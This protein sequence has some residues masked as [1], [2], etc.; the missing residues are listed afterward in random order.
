MQPLR[1]TATILASALLC[2]AAAQ[3]QD[4]PKRLA[5]PGADELKD[6]AKQTRETFKSSLS[7][8]LEQSDKN[9]V[10]RDMLA[11][12]EGEKNPALRHAM[13]ELSI[14]LACDSADLNLAIQ[15]VS[16]IEEAY[17]ED[18]APRLIQAAGD[19]AKAVRTPES[20]S[21]YFQNAQA[22][23]SRLLDRDQ[24]ATARKVAE[25]TAT[26]VRASSALQSSVSLILADLRELEA[27]HDKLA[28][29]LAAAKSDAE[30]ASLKGRHLCF[31]REKWEQGLPLLAAGH[32]PVLQPLAEAEIQKDA[33]PEALCA[34]ADAWDKQSEKLSGM[35]K[36]QVRSHAEFLYRDLLPKVG[37]LAKV[38]VENRLKQ[39][40]SRQA[41][42]P[43]GPVKVA[44]AAYVG[45]FSGR[46]FAEGVPDELA[47]ASTGRTL[48][49]SGTKKTDTQT[50]LGRRTGHFGKIGL[51]MGVGRRTGELGV[52]VPARNDQTSYAIHLVKAD[53]TL[54]SQAIDL[55]PNEKYAWQTQVD[56]NQMVLRVFSGRNPIATLRAPADAARGIGFSATVRHVGEKADLQVKW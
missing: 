15:G 5:P 48:H 35:A 36:R 51:L 56:G 1:T 33:T 49:I 53:G 26:A 29:A 3:A 6:A 8:A 54:E 19:T 28:R 50:V 43:G 34:V 42:A 20:G 24:V 12:S 11:A 40:E 4:A 47:I 32:D 14:D 23:I 16:K 39:I 46:T 7:A 2:L 37:G 22:L 52:T 27:A 9:Q 38:K 18:A 21:D 45:E 25:H 41:A 13:L 17:E 31:Y 30:K 55:K 10:A 44:K